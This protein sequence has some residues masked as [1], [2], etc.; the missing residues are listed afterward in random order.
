[1]S[2]VEVRRLLI[3]T[4]AW[5]II[6]AAGTFYWSLHAGKGNNGFFSLGMPLILPACLT[7][8]LTL[9]S[10]IIATDNEAGWGAFCG[11]MV[12]C[13]LGFL[14][15]LIFFAFVLNLPGTGTERLV[16]VRVAG[17]CIGALIGALAEAA[18]IS[19]I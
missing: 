10:F 7:I 9:R 15:I 4:L 18:C 11:T 16:L 12:G 6:W 17:A 3:S 2:R 19:W 13:L 5:A 1:M 8:W 14:S